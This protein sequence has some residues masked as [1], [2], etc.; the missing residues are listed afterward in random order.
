MDYLLFLGGVL[1]GAIISNILMYGFTTFGYLRIDHEH[2]LC[3]VQLDEM[4]CTKF[5]KRKVVL[6]IDHK[7]NL[8]QK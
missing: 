8:S 2:Q 4:D 6:E 7:A 1:F 5:H 3:Q